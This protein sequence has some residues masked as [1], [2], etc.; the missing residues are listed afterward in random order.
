MNP[1]EHVGLAEGRM[2]SRVRRV[3]QARLGQYSLDI[4]ADLFS[5]EDHPEPNEPYVSP[6]GVMENLLR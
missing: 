4:N 5:L 2:K 1:V 6:L 3:D